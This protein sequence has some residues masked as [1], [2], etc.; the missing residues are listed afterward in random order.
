MLDLWICQVAPVPS[1]APAEVAKR[2]AQRLA[3]YERY[4]QL[5]FELQLWTIATAGVGLTATA[6]FYTQV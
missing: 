1:F 5:Q 2:E 4:K 6:L 3:E